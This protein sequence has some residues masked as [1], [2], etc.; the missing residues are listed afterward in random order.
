[1]LLENVSIAISMGIRGSGARS[2]YVTRR[3]GKRER[4]TRFLQHTKERVPS[5]VSVRMWHG[6]SYVS[7]KCDDMRLHVMP[8]MDAS[9]VQTIHVMS[10]KGAKHGM[11]SWRSMT[12]SMAPEHEPSL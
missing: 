7:T 3:Q 8:V 10:V 12:V 2:A 4:Q 9:P 1:M 5:G 11:C 6:P